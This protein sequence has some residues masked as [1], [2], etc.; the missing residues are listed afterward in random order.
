MA[1]FR[2]SVITWRLP[3]G[4]VPAPG[5]VQHVTLSRHDP[6][7]G[8]DW[9]S[10]VKAATHCSPGWTNTAR[11]GCPACTLDTSVAWPGGSWV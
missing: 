1:S 9:H 10:R 8:C 6:Q 2:G 11:E 3:S 7:D 4:A 5:D